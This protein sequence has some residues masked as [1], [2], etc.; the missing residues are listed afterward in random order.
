MGDPGVV[1]G[2]ARNGRRFS[3]EIIWVEKETGEGV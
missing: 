3:G 2:V 1:L